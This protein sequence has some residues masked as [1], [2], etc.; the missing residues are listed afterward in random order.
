MTLKACLLTQHDAG[1]FRRQLPRGRLEFG[2][3]EF[4]A[5]VNKADVVF[6]FDELPAAG[7]V[8]PEGVPLVFIASEPE[9]VKR[10]KRRFLAQFDAVITTDR[11]TPHPRRIFSHPGIPWHVGAKRRGE[12]NADESFGFEEFEKY[13]PVKTKPVS[14]VASN[15][16]FTPEH[17]MRLRFVELLAAEMGDAVDVFGRG[18]RDFDDKVDVLSAYRYHIVLENCAREDYWTE[19]L[20]DPFLTLTYPIYFG[21]PNITDYFLSESMTL[22]DIYKPREAIEKIKQVV[23]SDLAERSSEHLREARRRVMNEHNIFGLMAWVAH[24]VCSAGS[25]IEP[26]QVKPRVLRAESDFKTLSEYP[27]S[28]LA[29]SPTL[30]KLWE[31]FKRKLR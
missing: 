2:G 25:I 20:A 13:Q 16:R 1:S 29:A 6:V 11:R 21:C 31:P 9:T 15:K 27:H 7:V 10:Y 4:F 23:S 26:Q 28:L 5:P 3:V 17:R 14:V 22:I 30:Q 12:K 24:E 8:A 19:K 18:I